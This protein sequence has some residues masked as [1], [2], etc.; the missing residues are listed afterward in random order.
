MNMKTISF[1]V[2]AFEQF[3]DWAT[4]DKRIFK[5]I[6]SLIRDTQ[7]DPF[8]GIGKPE[9]LNPHSA[10]LLSDKRLWLGTLRTLSGQTNELI[11]GLQDI[12][13]T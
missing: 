11:T 13:S 5:K 2:K 4:T 3:P 6:L 10:H 9:P 12:I 1:E 8:S 7:K